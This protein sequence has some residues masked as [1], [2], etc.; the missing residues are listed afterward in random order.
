[1]QEVQEKI[2]I[3]GASA[4]YRLE[5]DLWNIEALRTYLYLIAIWQLLHQ[6]T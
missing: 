6:E 5:Q 1:M 2:L 3:A 4:T